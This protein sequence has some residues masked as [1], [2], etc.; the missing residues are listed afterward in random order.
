MKIMI[1]II[2]LIIITINLIKHK[3]H[4]MKSYYSNHWIY[5]VDVYEI[6]NNLKIKYLNGE[7]YE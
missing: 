4:L 3:I 6:I 2:K 5:Q 7:N 1:N